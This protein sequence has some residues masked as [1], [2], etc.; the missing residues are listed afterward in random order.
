MAPESVHFSPLPSPLNRI[1]TTAM[2]VVITNTMYGLSASHTLT[3]L[4]PRLG[5]IITI[6]ILQIESLTEKFPN[7]RISTWWGQNLNPGGLAQE[8][9]LL[10]TVLQCFSF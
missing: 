5:S 6:P 8:P 9:M 10:T 3:H 4:I 2:T 1:T 7:V